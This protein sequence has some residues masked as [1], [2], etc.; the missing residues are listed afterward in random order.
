LSVGVTLANT[1]QIGGQ[2]GERLTGFAFGISPNATSVSLVDAAD[3]G[4]IKAGWASGAL[5]ANVPGVEIC[6]FGGVNCSGGANGGIYAGTSDF[7]TVLLGGTWGSS[8]DISPI[9]V[10]YQTG[11]GS[12]TFEATE[13]PEPSTVALVGLGLLGLGF[14]RFRRRAA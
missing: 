9:G 12:F 7:F 3:G 1:S 2:G 8:V 5:P 6:A 13:V 10:R 14:A 4:M 11:Y